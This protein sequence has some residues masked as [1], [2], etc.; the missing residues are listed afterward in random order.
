MTTTPLPGDSPAEILRA[1]EEL[2]E[3]F[4][5]ACPDLC[6]IGSINGDDVYTV[7]WAK[8]PGMFGR[9]RDVD[10]IGGLRARGADLSKRIGVLRL[11][12]DLR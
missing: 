8:K 3:A 6:H 7:E 5:E 1:A 12:G 10:A 4:A 2:L 11:R 9:Q